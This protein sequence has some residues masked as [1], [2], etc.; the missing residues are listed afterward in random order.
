[1]NDHVLE[2]IS[3]LGLYLSHDWINQSLNLSMK[4][5]YINV[6]LISVKQVKKSFRTRLRG[7]VKKF[8]EQG[9]GDIF[10]TDEIKDFRAE[11]CFGLSRGGFLFGGGRVSTP[12]HP[13][14]L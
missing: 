8:W 3:Y 7:G 5:L 12:L 14:V 6:D 9:R 10:S 13:I 11:G 2:L 1:M 4:N